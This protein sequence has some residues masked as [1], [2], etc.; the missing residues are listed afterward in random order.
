MRRPTFFEQ[1]FGSTAADYDRDFEGRQMRFLLTRLGLS[2]AIPRLSARHRAREGK[3]GLAF[4]DFH[5]AFPGFPVVLAFRALPHAERHNSC[6]LP[7]LLTRP[8]QSWVYEVFLEE[9]ARRFD[10]PAEPGRP[11]GLVFPFAAYPHGLVLHAAD[12]GDVHGRLQFRDGGGRRLTVEA[13]RSLADAVVATDWLNRPDRDS[14]PALDP[15]AA[16]RPW[17]LRVSPRLVRALGGAGPPALVAALLADLAA[18][19]YL[20]A[21][22]AGALRGRG[23]APWIVL[24]QGEV[25]ALTGLS[26][27]QVRRAVAGLVRRGL[28]RSERRVDERTGATKSHFRLEAG[29]QS[30]ALGDEPP[31]D[32]D[33]RDES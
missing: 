11:F 20:G 2:D 33:P 13:F 23:G 8:E 5:E 21:R 12:F 4:R 17:A 15:G 24:T 1:F 10:D 9:E 31:T 28:V 25:G 3:A 26:P 16:A 22:R 18:A 7:A 14:G 30:L 32:V 19:D 27:D 6:R 29:L